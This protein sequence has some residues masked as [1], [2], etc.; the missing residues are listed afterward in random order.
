MEQTCFFIDTIKGGCV[1]RHNA[2]ITRENFRGDWDALM[3]GE[4]VPCEWD[5]NDSP[6]AW[7][8]LSEEEGEED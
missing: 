2:V 6:I 1:Y 7:D 5:E 4:R 8:V 3:R